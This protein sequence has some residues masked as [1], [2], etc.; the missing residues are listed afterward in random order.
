MTV[1]TCQV[2]HECHRQKAHAYAIWPTLYLFVKTE[3]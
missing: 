1:K 3:A 2:S